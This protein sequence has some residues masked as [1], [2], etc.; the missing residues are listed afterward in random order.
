V[1]KIIHPTETTPSAVDASWFRGATLSKIELPQ[2]YG[3]WFRFSTGA[4]I[5]VECVWRIL[6]RSIVV[7]SEDHQQKFGLP[8]PFDALAR[9]SELLVGD[10]VRDFILRHDSLDLAFTFSRGHRLDIVPSSAGYEAWQ[11]VSP[12]RQHIIAIGGGRLDTYTDE[13]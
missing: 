12:Y 1:S 2:Q 8:A 13:T 10:T 4:S 3:W 11:I 9:A 5:M 6:D 7:T